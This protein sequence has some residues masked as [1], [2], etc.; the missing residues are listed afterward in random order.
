[1]AKPAVR[2]RHMKTFVDTIDA[3]EPPVRERIRARLPPGHV[4]AI[5]EAVPAVWLPMDINLAVTDAT[6]LELGPRDAQAFFRALVSAEYE[7]DTFRAFLASVARLLGL[8]P[9]TY[10]KMAPRG[11][12]LVFKNCG[13]LRP[14]ERERHRAWLE[15]TDIPSVCLQN[16]LWMESVRS[17]FYSAFDLTH[18][19]GEIRWQELDFDKRRAIFLFVWS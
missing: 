10:V 17:S 9:S 19:R 16:D 8:T 7:T 1:M 18:V 4:S 12:E 3:L 2:A 5:D 15:Y 11:W 13:A 14:L 6:S